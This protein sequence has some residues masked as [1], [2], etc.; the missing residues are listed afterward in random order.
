MLYVFKY[1][2]LNYICSKENEITHIFFSLKT[3]TFLLMPISEKQKGGKRGAIKI[4]KKTIKEK[5]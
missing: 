4:T 1:K 5:N 2:Y 3:F